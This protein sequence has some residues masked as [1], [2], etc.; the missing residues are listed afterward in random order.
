MA[1]KQAPSKAEK[2]P[3]HHR[4]NHPAMKAHKKNRAV[5][6]AH[7]K[8]P[9]NHRRRNHRRRNYHR[10]NHLATKAQPKNCWNTVF[11][12][13]A[14]TKAEKPPTIKKM[15]KTIRKRKVAW[16]TT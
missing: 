7:Q 2:T 3:K 8:K 11:Q 10:R 14:T 5:T 12:P 15:V 1:A 6:K 16:E 13:S 4:K 9:R